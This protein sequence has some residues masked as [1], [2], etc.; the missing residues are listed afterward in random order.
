MENNPKALQEA[1]NIFENLK[2]DRKSVLFSEK[3]LNMRL[4]KKLKRSSYS[5][6]KLLLKLINLI[7][8]GI[9]QTNKT[10]EEQIP[11]RL[12]YVKKAKKLTGQH[13]IVLMDPFSLSTQT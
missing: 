5:K 4:L 12:D 8:N 10:K 9:D 2:T 1:K 6:Y 3:K 13:Y 7:E 11:T